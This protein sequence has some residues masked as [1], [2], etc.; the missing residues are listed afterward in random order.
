M[1]ADLSADVNFLADMPVRA[2]LKLEDKRRSA[3][4]AL[5]KVAATVRALGS[6][7]CALDAAEVDVG[8][9][10]NAT[11]Y[12][13]D[14]RFAGDGDKLGQVWGLLRRAGYVT[15]NRPEKGDTQFSALW[16]HPEYAGIYMMF[17]STLCRRVQV[18]VQMVEQPVYEV[19]CGEWPELPTS[20][21]APALEALA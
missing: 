2:L 14:V 10:A 8:F 21:S 20:D 9:D 5:D 4:A 11:G 16:N 3:K 19:Q 18:G 1:S 6:L 12:P 15:T 13:I 7:F 17:S